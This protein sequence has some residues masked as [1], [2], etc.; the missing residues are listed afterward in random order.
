VESFISQENWEKSQQEFD[1]EE[2]E[3]RPCFVGGD[4]AWVEDMSAVVLVFP[5]DDGTFR[6]VPKIWVP[7]ESIAKRQRLSGAPMSQWE[8]D[9]L[10]STFPGG[11]TDFDIVFEYIERCSERYDIQMIGHDPVG[12][13]DIWKRCSDEIG[14]DVMKWSPRPWSMNDPIRGFEAAVM[15]ARIQHN[16]HPVL[17][18]NLSNCRTKVDNEDRVILVKRSKHQ[19]IDGIISAILGLACARHGQDSKG[20]KRRRISRET[21]VY[22]V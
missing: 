21:E 17:S 11:V 18:W 20:K 1:I 7:G 2:L 22:A 4:L 15:D 16:N 9:G 13:A 8:H 6:L 3:G 12:T 19:N 10:I 5:M 14:L